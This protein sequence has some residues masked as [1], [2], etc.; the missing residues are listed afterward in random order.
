MSSASFASPRTVIESAVSDS[1]YRS[2]EARSPVNFVPEPESPST[3]VEVPTEEEQEIS[4]PEEQKEIIV[5][6]EKKEEESS[7]GL[8]KELARLGHD[9]QVSSS[10]VTR[11]FARNIDPQNPGALQHT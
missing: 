10:L 9:S 8:L 4:Q 11:L 1:D 7:A 2:P 3:V 6:V 5:I